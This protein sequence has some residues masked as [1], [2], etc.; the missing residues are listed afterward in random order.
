MSKSLFSLLILVM[1]LVFF[2]SC[3]DNKVFTNQE[4]VPLALRDVPSQ[5]LNYSFESDVPEPTT[6][7]PVE[8]LQ[9]KNEAV[10]KHFDENR[11]LEILD[12]T[13][14]SPDKQRVLAVYRTIEDAE[15]HFRL[16]MYSVDG[17]LLKHITHDEM[18]VSYP[19]TI[20]WSPNSENAAF[21]AIV[22]P[23]N[24]KNSEKT[25]D[26]K[27]E[28]DSVKKAFQDS[29]LESNQNTDTDEKVLITNED[30]I[31]DA[32][33]PDEQSTKAD[34]NVLTF[35]TLQIYICNGNGGALK[36]LT[37]R[38]GLMYF[39][40]TWSP[41]SSM[42][43]ALAAPFTEWK[44]RE[45]QMVNLGERFVPLGRPRIVEKNGV[46]RLLDDLPTSVYP[47]WSSDSAKVAV[48]Y[49]KQVR[50][51]DTIG[52]RRTQ[53]AIPLKNQLLLSS[54][55]FDEQLKKEEEL[56]N[57]NS[58]GVEKSG[59]ENTNTQ[60]KSKTSTTLPDERSLV[61]FNPIINLVWLQDSLL[62]LQTGYVKVFTNNQIEDRNSYLRWHRLTLSPQ[63]SAVPT[64]N[65]EQ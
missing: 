65:K 58:E 47:V 26:K 52:A 5:R 27:P 40:F 28:K 53:A 11:T 38:E 21:I 22:R 12:R 25:D 14:T 48:A 33:P 59:S 18:A 10:Q 60:V 43:A 7:E 24:Q 2:G 15:G 31:I 36:P 3:K 61:S 63:A 9:S 44:F 32:V 54:K 55:T 20:V 49:N 16:D 17:K 37:S 51:Y 64:N 23:G 50:I 13:I 45:L 62:Y 19:D 8:D 1:I 6:E 35:R 57:S 34:E 4:P 39:Y 41:D 42:I 46:E 30:E 56:D 29:D